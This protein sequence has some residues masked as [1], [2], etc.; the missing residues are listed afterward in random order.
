MYK[1]HEV[2][3]KKIVVTLDHTGGGLKAF[4][5]GKP[6]GFAIAGKDQKF[7]AADA[8]LL[9]GD[10]VEVWSDKVAEPVAVRY[11]WADNPVCNLRSQNGLPV[12]PFRSDD[13][14]GVTA[15]KDK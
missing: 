13:W 15:G 6:T 11:A 10:K 12:T 3:G 1:S 14:P 9:G 7:V 4:D 2:Q 8:T 5:T